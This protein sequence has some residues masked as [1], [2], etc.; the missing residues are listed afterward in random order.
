M[1]LRGA[2][3]SRTALLVVLLWSMLLASAVPSGG[4]WSTAPMAHAASQTIASAQMTV[5]VDDQFPRVIDYTMAG[6]GAKLYGQDE[7]LTQVKINGTAYTPAVTFAKPD[8]A[9][10]QYAMNIASIGVTVNATLKVVGS[11]LE[12]K[13]TGITE[14]GATKV[15]TFEIPNQNLLSV[16]STQTGAAFAGSVMNTAVTGSGDTFANVTGTPATNASA[17]NYLYG[18][19]NTNQLAG[20]LWTNAVSESSEAGRVKK[21]TVSRTGFYRTGLW[22]GEWI[23]RANG[24]TAPDAELPQAKVAIAADANGDSVVDWQDGAVAFRSIM[25]NPQGADKVK[26]W[27]VQRVPM[28]F[29]SQATNPFTKT[30]DETK[31]MN[32]ATDG[33]GQFVLLKG[34]GSEGHDSGHPDYGDIGKRQGGAAEL[35][36]LVNSGHAYNAAF[37]VHINA[38]ESYPEAK[39]FNEQ[40]VNPASPGWDWLDASYYNNKRND[41]SSGNRLAR[42]Q[43]LKAQAPNL[44]FIY[45]DVWYTK[46]WD[47]RRIGGEINSQGWTLATEFPD[48]HE[49]NAVWNH[50]AVDYNYGGQDIKG[51]SSQ[52]AR[53]IR[54]HQKD[55]WI[56]RHPLLGGTE[57]DDYEGW[58]GRTGFDDTVKMTFGTNLPTKYV[59]HFPILKWTT[60]TIQL[61]QGVTVSDAT[62]T[63]VITKNGVKV[64]EGNK[65]LLPWSPVTEDKL[66]HWNGIGGG[67]T[68]TLPAS[69]SG[70][71]AA[72]LYR[73]SDQGRVL[74]GDLP[75][76]GGT[77]TIN[78]T[79]NTAYVVTKTASGAVPAA[80]YGE[81]SKLKDPGFNQGNLTNTWTVAGS[82][83]SVVRS[84]RGDY[85][86]KV[87][88]AAGATTISQNVTGLAPGTYYASVYVS[89]ASGRKAYLDATSGGTTTSSYA[90]S[91]LWSNYI[92]ADAKRDT[93]MQRMYVT[94]DVPSGANSATI[95]LRTDGG[96]AAVTFDDARI[97]A[98][99]R[100]PNPNNAYFVQNFEDV[101]SGLYPFIKG[102]AGGVNDPR[103]HLSELHAPYTQKGWNGKAIDDVIAGN[104]SVKAHS[105]A[106]GLLLQTIPQTLRFAPGTNYTVSFQYENQTE[107]AYAFV[108]GEGTAVVSAT[109]FAAATAPTTYTQAITGSAGG[110]T[111]VGIQ[112]ANG[113]AGDFVLDDLVVTVGGSG[114]GNTTPRIKITKTD[115][116]AITDLTIKAE[117][118]V[119]NAPHRD[120]ALVGAFDQ[121]VAMSL[122][123]RNGTQTGGVWTGDFLKE[124]GRTAGAAVVTIEK[125][126]TRPITAITLT[127]EFKIDGALHRDT[128]VISSFDQSYDLT[129]TG[130]NGTLVDGVWT[131]DFLK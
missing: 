11:M 64:L 107:G 114:G 111:W 12:F 74:V 49:Y 54:N 102:P 94:F 3:H 108:V 28:N 27:V 35:N 2:T 83:A 56:A 69:W 117:F 90:D 93:T 67:T 39:A 18:F 57:M 31:R 42:L 43:S 50:W 41:A 29:G 73:L 34:Y 6:S 10:A 128:H 15:N 72:K 36:T 23:Y 91:S 63:R 65:Y 51:Y 7:T 131:G 21:Q 22:S 109:P 32:L 16:R 8:G 113:S 59:Q 104:W 78:A 120:D 60:N 92:S 20:G 106:Q 44:D 77:I 9:T 25:N 116:R 112:K 125:T 101:P 124:T 58:Q 4:G 53:F 75:V 103:T 76:S 48:D 84:A 119:E 81:G 66:Y 118:M 71:S 17:Q 19:V 88:T 129:L 130:A 79:A 96:S 62:G 30:L 98:T 110:N 13:V 80:N 14:S 123:A 1:F 97:G 46:G 52:I 126:D 55:T 95:A 40:L 45:L 61:E 33:L 87:G 24:M 115:S 70:A 26:S 85:E 105:E 127:A 100:T 47:A 122:S 86:L 37:G 121:S 38:T 99:T 89:T 82:G 68:W 5:T